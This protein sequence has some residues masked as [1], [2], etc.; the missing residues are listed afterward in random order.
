MVW[1]EGVVDMGSPVGVHHGKPDALIQAWLVTYASRHPETE[2]YANTTVI[3]DAKNTVQPDALLRRLPEHGGLT[4][5]TEAGYF[6]GP[7]ELTVEVAASSASI[8]L[9]DK[10]R[11]CCRNGVHEYQ[12]WLVAEARLGHLDSHLPAH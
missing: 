4:R 6:A 1:I 12:V 10:R 3:L 5:V 9:W 11:A 7:S 2:A 8:D